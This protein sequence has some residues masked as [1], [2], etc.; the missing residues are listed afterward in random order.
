M[1]E[2]YVLDHKMQLHNK[3]NNIWSSIHHYMILLN[4][5]EKKMKFGLALLSLCINTH[6]TWMSI[7][8]YVLL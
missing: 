8:N 3:Y 7:H 1:N 5:E 2:F 4:T 6:Y